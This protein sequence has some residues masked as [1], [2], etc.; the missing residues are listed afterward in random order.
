MRG[1]GKPIWAVRPSL[2]GCAAL[3]LGFECS[4]I[5]SKTLHLRRFPSLSLRLMLDLLAAP[6]ASGHRFQT[7]LPRWPPLGRFVV[8][9]LP[10]GVTRGSRLGTVL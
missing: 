1:E 4:G 5:A 6:R 7:L 10:H 2:I 9:V 3:F 8:Q